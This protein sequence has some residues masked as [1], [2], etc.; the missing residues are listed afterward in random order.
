[1]LALRQVSVRYK[2]TAIGIGWVLLQPLVAMGIFS[3]VFGNFAKIPSD[4]IPYPIF[5]YSAL[6]LWGL[7]SDGL[8]RAGSSLIAE[9]RLISKV[10]FPR[11]IIPL[12][13]VGSAWVD[14]AVSLF[15]LLP[16]TYIYHLRPTW[17]LLLLP[18][19]MVVTMILGAGV[20]MLLAALNVKYRDFQ[21]AVPFVMQIWLYASPIVYS[22]NLV[23]AS[24]RPFYYLNPMAGLIELCRF[25]VTGQGNFS[26]I[27]LSLSVAGAIAF[28]IIGSTVFRWVERSFADFI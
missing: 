9:E 15:L 17:S 22:V 23:P 25:A 7:F 18:V 27:G 11:L 14:F 4:G 26:L 5:S 21:Y 3:V 16:L 6:I 28:F 8:T 19:A 1:M 12:A 20:G 10:Y 13:A 24:I 2:Q